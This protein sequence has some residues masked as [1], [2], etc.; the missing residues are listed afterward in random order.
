MPPTLEGRRR[1]GSHDD[2][3]TAGPADPTGPEGS[4]EGSLDAKRAHQKA[5][6]AH[7]EGGSKASGGTGPMAKQRTLPRESGG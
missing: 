1:R 7:L 6:Q 3:R 2:S 4:H 5:G